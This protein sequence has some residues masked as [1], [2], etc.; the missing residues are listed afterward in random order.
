LLATQTHPCSVRSVGC[1]SVVLFGGCEAIL[2]WQYLDR[3]PRLV[4]DSEGVFD[5]VL[6]IGRIP[7]SQIASSRL[8]TVQGGVFVC[9][10]LVDHDSWV[11]KLPRRL[12]V[13]SA[14]NRALGFSEIN[15]SISNL[16]TPPDQII[17][18]ILER[19]DESRG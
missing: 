17:L 7:W 16:E 4:I 19:L 2:L 8:E 10:E 13:F 12:R 1:I 3:R 6:G 11:A 14:A 15:L 18:L 9:L 5:R